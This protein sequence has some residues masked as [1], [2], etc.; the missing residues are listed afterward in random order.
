MLAKTMTY[1]VAFALAAASALRAPTPARHL[2]AR[3]SL[4]RV[5][6]PIASPPRHSIALYGEDD[7]YS[8]PKIEFSEEQLAAGGGVDLWASWKT[9]IYGGSVLIGLALPL[10]F[11]FVR[12]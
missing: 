9:A 1:V 6:T 10:F 3:A 12:P 4:N 2:G 11:F 7:D 8:A 5:A